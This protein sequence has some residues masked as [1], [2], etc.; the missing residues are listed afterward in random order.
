MPLSSHQDLGLAW[1]SFGPK[2]RPYEGEARAA[3]EAVQCL[4][5]RN[6]KHVFLHGDAQDIIE[7]ILGVEESQMVVIMDILLMTK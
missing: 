7:E 5:P 6:V 4:V 2:S 1:S 3:M